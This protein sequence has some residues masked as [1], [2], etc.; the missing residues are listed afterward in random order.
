[1]DLVKKIKIVVFSK[2]QYFLYIRYMKYIKYSFYILYIRI[3]VTIWF[4]TAILLSFYYRFM[5]YSPTLAFAHIL[6][7]LILRKIREAY[8]NTGK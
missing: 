5:L 7:M 2:L 1:M 8:Q 3:A 6:A 4:V